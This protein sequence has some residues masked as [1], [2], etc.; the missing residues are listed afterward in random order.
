MTR[1]KYV[2]AMKELVRPH[3]AG[4][5]K[6]LARSSDKVKELAASKAV[7]DKVLVATS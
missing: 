7:D 5:H 2:A 6:Q 3:R 1:T 4:G